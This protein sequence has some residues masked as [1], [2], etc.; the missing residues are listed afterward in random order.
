MTRDERTP[1]RGDAA[2]SAPRR[3]PPARQPTVSPGKKRT[4]RASAPAARG[5][6]VLVGLMSGTSADG[7][8]AVVARIEDVPETPFAAHVAAACAALPRSALLPSRRA[9]LLAH[10]HVSFEPGFRERVLALPRALPG[11]LALLHVELGRRF[12]DAALAAVRAARLRPA[13]VAAACTPGLTAAHLPPD[14]HGAGATLALGDGDVVAARCGLRVVCDVRAADRA[15]GGQGA[16][17]V[18]W[19]DAVLLRPRAR[20]AGAP[21]AALNL[22]GI[23]NLSVVPP[24]GDPIAF[25]TG[26][27]NML[28][29]G[30]VALATRGALTFDAGGALA[31]AGRVDEAWLA[32]LLEQ[33]D[34]LRTPPPRSTGRERYGEAWLA[35]HA[36]RLRRARPADLAA[37]LAAYTVE[38]VARALEDFVALQPRELIV[39]GGGALN[40]AL[41]RGLA[42]RLPDVIVHDSATA[43]GLPPMVREALAFALIGDATLRGEP[44][45]V[46]S[47]TGARRAVVLGKLCAAGAGVAG[48][49]TDFPAEAE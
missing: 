34:F 40:L 22:G 25:D 48:Q 33:D 14:A 21:V 45:N 35:R 18:P 17:L 32:Q 27:G 47:V 49:P 41:L 10:E 38:A 23:A 46:P 13:D 28:L 11:E 29:D 20:A 1:S 31:L 6:R 4:L 19:A 8:D 7:V 3:R 2:G 26:P 42:R 12:G 39:S 15:A 44:A 16:P 5:A 36:E 30:A 43:L 24:D 9:T 37:T